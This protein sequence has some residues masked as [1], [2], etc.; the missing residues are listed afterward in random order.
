MWRVVK[1]RNVS[2]MTQ[3]SR[4]YA[5]IVVN[6]YGLLGF[7]NTNIRG[8]TVPRDHY[9]WLCLTEVFVCYDQEG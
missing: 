4:L 1:F 3:F 6:S 2:A 9:A 5:V 7:D 8:S